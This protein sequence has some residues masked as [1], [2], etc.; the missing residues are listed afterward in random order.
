MSMRIALE[1][2]K[3][4]GGSGTLPQ[5]RARAIELGISVDGICHELRN[6]RRWHVVEAIPAKSGRLDE[7]VWRIIGDF[8]FNVISSETYH[9]V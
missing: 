1:L 8:E 7:V 6:L 2:L 9:S 4:L 3:S 5:M